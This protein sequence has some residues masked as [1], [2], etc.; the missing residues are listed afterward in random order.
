MPRPAQIRVLCAVLILPHSV[1]AQQRPAFDF[2]IASIMR[3]PELYG[4]EPQRVRWS[5]DGRTIYFYWNAPGTKWSE[6]LQPYRVADARTSSGS[7]K[8]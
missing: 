6:P 7:G 5:G 2:S 4:R 8:Q 1:P 3:E